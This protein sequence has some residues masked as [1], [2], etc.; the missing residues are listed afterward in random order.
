[1][2]LVK[3]TSEQAKAQGKIDREQIGA[4]TEADIA[5]FNAEDGFDPDD[6]L[7]GLRRVHGPEE[8]RAKAGVT[9]AEMAQRLGVPLKTWRNWEQGRVT[10]EPSVRAL[11]ALV[12]DDPERAFAILDPAGAMLGMHRR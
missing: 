4:M 8:I 3:M 7:K 1:M 6:T 2:A 12:N 11:L 10:L 5:R 9:Q